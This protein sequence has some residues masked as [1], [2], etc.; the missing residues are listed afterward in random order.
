MYAD[1]P[2]NRNGLLAPTIAFGAWLAA[3]AW[4]MFHFA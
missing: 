1:Q 4:M 3:F 2:Q